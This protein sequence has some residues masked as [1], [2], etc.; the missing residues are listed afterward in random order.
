MHAWLIPTG[1]A[2]LSTCAHVDACV[3]LKAC[4][5]TMSSITLERVIHFMALPFHSLRPIGHSSPRLSSGVSAINTVYTEFTAVNG[6]ALSK[7]GHAHSKALCVCLLFSSSTP[8]LAECTPHT[9]SASS[10][11]AFGFAAANIDTFGDSSVLVYI[12]TYMEPPSRQGVVILY[13]AS[14]RQGVVHTDSY[15]R[16]RGIKH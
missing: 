14:S 7:L 5:C 4:G 16:S 10:T 3:L 2:T 8:T 11:P 1:V 15:M 6:D 13:E 12:V 9:S